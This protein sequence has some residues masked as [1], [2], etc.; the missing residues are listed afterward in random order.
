[1]KQTFNDIIKISVKDLKYVSVIKKINGQWCNF[2]FSHNYFNSSELIA[3]TFVALHNELKEEE[4]IKQFEFDGFL[5]KEIPFTNYLVLLFLLRSFYVR[6]DNSKDEDE[7]TYILKE[8]RIGLGF[9][10]IEDSE[11]ISNNLFSKLYAV[12]EQ[13][14]QELLR[15]IKE[16]TGKDKFT[17][18]DIVDIFGKEFI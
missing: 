16:R 2:G 11:I 6:Y 13:D 8:I 7:Y 12:K 15:I 1:M 3:K 9:D 18:K 4:L 14:K 17:T 5:E 10:P